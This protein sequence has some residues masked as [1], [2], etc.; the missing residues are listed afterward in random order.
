MKEIDRIS[1]IFG[2]LALNIG[3]NRPIFT[4]ADPAQGTAFP[5]SRYNPGQKHPAVPLAQSRIR[6]YCVRPG[7]NTGSYLPFK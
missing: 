1:A 7:C 3:Q 2:V 4:H 6:V 5:H